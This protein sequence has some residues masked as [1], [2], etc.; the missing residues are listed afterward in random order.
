MDEHEQFVSET[1]VPVGC[2]MAYAAELSEDDLRRAGWFYCHGQKLTDTPIGS[3]PKDGDDLHPLFLAIGH[4][5]GGEG[6]EF[7][8]PD[9][10]GL[11]LR[12][13]SGDATET[14]P[15]PGVSERFAAAPGGNAKE[16]V[17]SLQWWATAQPSRAFK[18]TPLD[19]AASGTQGSWFGLSWTG[20]EHTTDAP[21]SIQKF[22]GGDS[23]TSASNVAVHY[24]IKWK[25]GAAIPVGAVF[26]YAG[27][28]KDSSRS[29]A[30]NLR[31][32]DGS[33]INRSEPGGDLPDLFEAIGYR[34]GGAG[35]Q[36]T[37]PDYRGRFLRGLGTRTNVIDKTK[38]VSSG[39]TLGAVQGSST[40]RPNVDFVYKQSVIS[41]SHATANTTRLPSDPGLDV[42]CYQPDAGGS[43]LTIDLAASGGDAESRPKNMAMSHHIVTGKGNGTPVVLPIGSVIC[44]PGDANPP[45]NAWTKCEC[46]YL[47][48][49]E[50]IYQALFDVIGY[51]Y[52]QVENT[53]AVPDLRGRFLRDLDGGTGN[54][55]DVALRQPIVKI[56][57]MPTN[58][59]A[60]IQSCATGAPASPIMAVLNVNLPRVRVGIGCPDNSKKFTN[61]NAGMSLSPDGGGD[62][63]TRP[64]NASVIFY[65][66][67]G[68]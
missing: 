12:G 35:N 43:T 24:I 10:R 50:T 56:P 59:T 54:D 21:V 3:V 38:T 36:F 7:F 5:N 60:S 61:A 8:L 19:Y 53:Y 39:P 34:Y 17:G 29:I 58:G 6:S 63:E 42:N 44:I 25:Q 32:C 27:I 16:A 23:E 18:S 68:A 13:N 26:A 64:T 11:F 1:N 30:A 33:S 22:T 4:C 45:G 20:E 2:V 40:A 49:K 14:S 46:V 47:D 57:G 65:I 48:S 55:P 28:G 15:D 67:S 37:L 66:K 51:A 41:N 9:Y 31:R 62:V 52:G